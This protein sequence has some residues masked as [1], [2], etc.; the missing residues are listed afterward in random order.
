MQAELNELLLFRVNAQKGALGQ[1]TDVY[2]DDV[3]WRVRYLAVTSEA[4][5][6]GLRQFL[7][8]PEVI[9]SVE[10]HRGLITLVSRQAA[11]YSRPV[12]ATARNISR[13]EEGRVRA[14]YGLPN[15][16]PNPATPGTDARAPEAVHTHLHRLGEVLGYRVFVGQD[17]IGGLLN[18]AMDD[19]TWEIQ[20]LEVDASA[21]LPAGRIWVRAA[22]I[23]RVRE[24]EREIV[25]T[26]FRTAAAQRAN[27]DLP[28]HDGTA[29]QPLACAS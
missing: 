20:N 12:V 13:Q 25:L 6:S 3:S 21:W 17:D 7:L 11:I 24:R 29:E 23:Q 5:Q 10:R 27:A 2:F 19:G 22:C 26:K 18:L 8:T 1:V 9:G 15:Y 16:W 14:F 4:G 28:P